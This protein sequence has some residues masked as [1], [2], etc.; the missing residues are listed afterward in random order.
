MATVCVLQFLLG[1]SDRQAAEAVRCRID[2]KYAL[3]LELDDPGFHHSVLSDLRERLAEDDRA[4]RLLDLALVRLKDAGLVRER[5]TRRTDST[6]V[7]AAVRD[8]T[9]LELVTEAVRAALEEVARTAGHLLVGLADED[10]GRRYGRPVRLGKNP[11]RPKTRILAAGDDACRLLEHLHRHGPG[12]RP[13]PQAEALRQI[14]VQNYYRDTAGR[15]RWR[16]A[17][18][19]GLPP[20]SLAVVSPYDTT[21]RYVRRWHIIRWKGFAAHLTETCASGSVNV[22][23]DVATTSAAT[24]DAQ[25]LPGIHTRLARRGLLPAEHLVDGGYI[26]LVHLERTRWA[27]TL[28]QYKRTAALGGTFVLLPHDLWGAD[29]TTSQGWPGDNGDWTQFDAFVTQLISDV[30]ANNMTVQWDLWNE[31]D[32]SGFWGASQTQYLQMWSRFYA[33]VRAALPAQL[34]VGPSIVGQPN[35][36]NTWWTT[37]LAYIKANNL[38]PDIYSWHD[39]PGD[40]VTDV[41]RANSTLTAA[42]LTNTRPYQINEYATLSMQSPGGGAWFIGRLERAGADG[43]RGNWASG[44][45]LHDDEAN[46]LTKNSAGQYLPLGEWFMYRYYG[47][48]TGNIVNLIPGTGTDGLATKDN[49]AGNAKVLL[50]SSGNTGTGTVTLN[51][52]GLNTTSVVANSQVRVVVQRIPYNSGAAVTGPETIADTTLTVSGNA[53][54]VSLPWTNA[55]DGYTVTLLPPSN[56][57]VSTVAVSQNS[58]Q[59]LDDTNRSTANSTQYQQYYCEG[60]YQQMLDLKPV[61]GKTNTYSVVDELSSKCLDV[62]GASTADGAAVIQYT[63]NNA[64]NQQFTLNP[65]T[66]LGNSHDYQLVAVHSGKCVDVSNVSTAAGAQIHQWTCDAASVLNTKKNQIWRLLG[67][68]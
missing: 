41:G 5:T 14:V 10:W 26:S 68:S 53:P 49:S 66:A 35:S 61:S 40:P 3:A 15:L 21:A 32:G 54:S 29:G 24:N 11:T 22:I 60:G 37:Y 63:C 50:G 17:D 48:Q 19:G 18:E 2:F 59:C 44:T 46:L 31:P 55:K 27:S 36:S 1:L 4:D 47:S 6:H 16:T 12:R 20:Y 57:T 65:V 58:G 64:T 33:K 39:E 8:L 34:I 9:R 51:L 30:K 7:L 52:T 23:T 13:G 43:L 28:A 42:G 56:T 38:A 62:S 25:S 45:G 67:K